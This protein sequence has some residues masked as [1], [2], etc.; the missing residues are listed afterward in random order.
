MR[1]VEATLDAWRDAERLL[2]QLT[3]DDPD[4][5]T[6][7]WVEAT[8]KTLYHGVTD[9]GVAPRRAEAAHRRTVAAMRRVLDRVRERQ[10][11][12]D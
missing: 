10:A 2:E 6:V 4:Y 8:L 7:R 9:E 11:R 12:T 1:L 5:E 3:P